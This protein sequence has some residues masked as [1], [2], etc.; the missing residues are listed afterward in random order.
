M[1]VLYLNAHQP[2]RALEAF[3]QAT[4]IYDQTLP[5]LYVTGAEAAFKTGRQSLAE[6]LLARLERACVHCEHYYEY[7]AEAALDRGDTAVAD[8][9]L[10]RAKRSV[11]ARHVR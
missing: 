11:A 10:A 5:W 1:V 4:R 7:E 8:T 6:S 9:L 2:G 3:Q